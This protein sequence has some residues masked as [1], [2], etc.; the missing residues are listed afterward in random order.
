MSNKFNKVGDTGNPTLTRAVIRQLGGG[1]EAKENL[2]DVSNHGADAGFCG[3]VYYK[4][5]VPFFEK[6]RKEILSVLE[7]DAD[8]FGEEPAQIVFGFNCLRL[9]EADREEQRAYRG[10]ISRLL[11]G[12]RKVDWDKPEEVMVANALSWYGLETVAREMVIDS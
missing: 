10:A 2:I 6:H 12:N 9:K 5:T 1:S 8:S 7:E 11:Y 3:F 4:D